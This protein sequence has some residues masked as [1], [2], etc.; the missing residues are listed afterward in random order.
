M[1]KNKAATGGGG[2]PKI[3]WP[4]P[5]EIPKGEHQT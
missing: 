1:V 4:N 5:K 2:N 3:Q